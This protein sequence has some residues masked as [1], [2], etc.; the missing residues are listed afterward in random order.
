MT[1]DMKLELAAIVGRAW[2]RDRRWPHDSANPAL[3]W[4]MTVLAEQEPD[5][6]AAAIPTKSECYVIC[7]NHAAAVRDAHKIILTAL[8]DST[9]RDRWQPIETAP[10][11]GRYIVAL[12]RSLDGYAAHLDGRA[13]VVR[14]E[15]VTPSDYDLGWALYPGYGGVPDKCLS[16]WI[17]L[18]PA[19]GESA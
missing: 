8:R 15:G 5:L 9:D 4:A 11:D 10:R 2:E 1:K 6:T 19:P 12:Y 13:F 17:P 16:A 18:P 14:H 7:G 3:E